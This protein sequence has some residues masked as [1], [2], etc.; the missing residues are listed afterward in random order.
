M[1]LLAR[2]AA[3][4]VAGHAEIRERPAHRGHGIVR[5]WPEDQLVAA[6]LQ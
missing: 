1:L 5:R 6:I 2:S 4:L 3:K